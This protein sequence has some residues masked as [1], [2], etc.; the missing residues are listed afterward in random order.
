[1]ILPIVLSITISIDKPVNFVNSHNEKY[2]KHIETNYSQ[3]AYQ[4]S[5]KNMILQDPY[6]YI[7]EKNASLIYEK[8]AEELLQDEE[9]KK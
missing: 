6:S 7:Q 4:F 9:D 2:I 8:L 3:E 5:T 1:M